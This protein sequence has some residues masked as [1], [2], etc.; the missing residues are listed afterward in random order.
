M[1]SEKSR[2][3]LGK[4]SIALLQHLVDP[5]VGEKFITEAQRPL[6]EKELRESLS[7]A[8]AQTEKQ[9][10]ENYTNKALAQGL[11]NLPISD[12]PDVKK[13]VQDFYD[14]PNSSELALILGRQLTTD[15]TSL[16]K[17][18]ITHAVSQFVFM[19][20]LEL[21]NVDPEIRDKLATQSLLEIAMRLSVLP[22]S[23]YEDQDLSLSKLPP[24]PDFRTFTG[25][26]EA[27][28]DLKVR[29]GVFG[30]KDIKKLTIMRGWPGVGKT[31]LSTV[32]AHQAD[33][34]QAF[35]DGIFWTSLGDHPN[36]MSAVSSW[37]R[38]LNITD[39]AATSKNLGEAFDRLR[40]TFI[41]KKALIIVDDVYEVKHGKLFRDIVGPQCV[42][43]FTTRDNKVAIELA[44]I[45]ERDSYLLALLS[46]EAALELLR[47][48]IPEAVEQYPKESLALVVALEGLPL[49]IQVAGRMLQMEMAAGLSIAQLLESLRESTRIMEQ[50]SPANSI[51][52]ELA[53]ETNLTV[54]ALL[55]KS[56]DYLEDNNRENFAFLGAFAPKPAT[57]DIEAMK[58][59]WE[60]DDPTSVIRD[61]VGRGL[62]EYD[63]ENNRY[64][65][66]ALLVM[67]A[68]Y[69]LGDE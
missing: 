69:L 38:V 54:A 28:A 40:T 3:D 23:P 5:I 2:Y 60:T 66:H 50:V 26:E 58:A 67:L 24:L 4:L 9:F 48:L 47:R 15:F 11:I 64:Q 43:L 7:K 59:L 57:F 36:L 8:L 17:E 29:I 12:L 44:E 6:V 14:R 55:M 42:V 52:I 65:M 41:K 37:G 25:R 13:A 68:R 16:P 62:L 63:E 61:L 39:L 49:A 33:V 46:D 56:I 22:L 45:R 51:S 18:Q 27:L 34:K 21:I 10:I 19:L 35:P 32:L 20:R 31:T 53:N 1:S 30:T